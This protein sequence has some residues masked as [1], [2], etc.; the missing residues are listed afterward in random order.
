MKTA[1]LKR[2]VR[3]L[4]RPD[5]IQSESDRV[6]PHS[7]FAKGRQAIAATLLWLAT[8]AGAAPAFA[9]IDTLKMMIGANP[10]GGFDQTGRSIAAAM[11]AAGSVRNATFENKGGAG[12]TIGLAQF[13]NTEKGNPNALIVTGAVMVGAI[14]MSHPPVTLKNGTPIARLFAD[15]MVLV[16]PSG[17][18]IQSMSDLVAMLKANPGSVSWAGGSRGS[19]DHMLAGLIAKESGVEP[20]KVNYI[21]FAGGGEATAAILGNQ[22]TVGIAG[23]SEFMPFVKDGKMRALAVSSSFPVQGIKPLKDLG[24]NVEMYNWRG[25]WGPPGITPEQQKAMIDAVV[26]GTQTP[27]WKDTLARN[28]WAPFLQ[29]GAEFGSYVESESKRLGGILRDLGLAK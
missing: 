16:V 29:T 8:L 5:A 14:E 27:Q 25:V 6:L 4:G 11:Q 28:D 22:V 20:A 18:K 12:G 10:G 13:V 1:M 23:V 26:K 21:P 3:T 24:V 9:Q 7:K 17:S 19:T 15:A 2:S